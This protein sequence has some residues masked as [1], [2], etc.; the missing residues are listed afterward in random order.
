MKDAMV[1]MK[2]A[3]EGLKNELAGIKNKKVNDMATSDHKKKK[4]DL[5]IRGKKKVKSSR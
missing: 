5:C 4:S 2:V 3:I 1:G